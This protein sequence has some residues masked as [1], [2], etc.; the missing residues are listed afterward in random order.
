MIVS[1]IVAISKNNA[2]G[3]ENQIPWYLPADLKYFKNVTLGH[4]VIMGRKT[5][6]SIG[7]PLPKRTNVVL[8]RDPFYTATGIVVAQSL[9]EA[10]EIAYD[11][12]ETEAFIIGGGELY[13]ESASLWDKI[14]LTKVDL[15][16][17]DAEV[18]F[19]ETDPDHWNL[20]A[21]DCREA[22]EKNEM[23]YCFLVYER[24]AEINSNN[25][26][27]YDKSDEPEE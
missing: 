23:A 6:E 3:R 16:V 11:H 25:P 4:H 27:V 7:R 2:I 22:D 18:F 9:E 24:K 21:E 5:F 26:L 20:I 10:L 14:Y 8:T 19:P 15:H 1:A 17:D 12:G 13:K